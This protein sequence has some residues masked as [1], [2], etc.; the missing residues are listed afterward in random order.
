M[1][2]IGVDGLRSAGRGRTLS[3]LFT[4]RA[5]VVVHPD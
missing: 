5:C 3:R 1:R 4:D 2:E